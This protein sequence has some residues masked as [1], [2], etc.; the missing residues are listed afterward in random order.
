MAFLL[1]GY[2]VCVC[3]SCNIFLAPWLTVMVAFTFAGEGGSAYDV[4]GC[5]RGSSSPTRPWAGLPAL[6]VTPQQGG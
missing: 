6:H 3:V 1:I 2:C 4:C 5:R